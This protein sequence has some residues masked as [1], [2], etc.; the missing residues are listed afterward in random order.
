MISSK[1]I[2]KK[3]MTQKII[4]P[5]GQWPSEIT[6][7]IFANLLK[8]SE[9]AW[10]KNGSLFWR[11]RS[12]SL[13]KIQMS[14][15]EIGQI[16]TIS[17]DLNVGGELLY[18]GGGYSTTK[19]SLITVDKTTH[20]LYRINPNEAK[21]EELTSSLVSA[22]SPTVSPDGKY[23][24]F[25]HSDGETDAI[26][27]TGVSDPLSTQ[28]LISDS[29]F[30][31]YPR[32]HPS[33]SRIAWIS[34]DHPHMPWDESYL[35]LAE[36]DSSAGGGPVLTSK[37][38]IAGGDGT[39]VLQPEFSPDGRYLAYVSEQDGWWQIFLQDLETGQNQ[40]LTDVHAEHGLPAWLQDQRSFQFSPDSCKIFF[41]R[42]QDGIRTLWT[43]DLGSTREKMIQLDE[44]YTW[45]EDISISPDG[46][47]LA[48]IASGADLP[49]RLITV[50]LEGKTRIIRRSS[51]VQLPRDI[52]SIPEPVSW[53]SQEGQK[54]HGL[55]YFPQNSQYGGEGKPPLVMIIHSGP[56]RQKWVDFQTRTQY[57]TSRG[58][59]VLEV[60]Y[61]GSTGYGRQ[62][63]QALKGNWGVADVDDC[64][65]GAIHLA[66]KEL[67]DRKKMVVMGSSSGGMTVYQILV[68]YPG[69]F[70]A[71]ISL[72]GIVNHLSLLKNPPKFERHYSDWLIGHYPE[73][74]EIYHQRSPIFSADNIQDPVA[75][76]QGGK[77]RIVPQDQAEQIVTALEE[78]H[79]PYLYRLYPEE[80]H[81][82]KRVS[83][84]EDFYT[85]L[86]S[87]L[88]T[89]LNK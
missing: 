53:T 30:Y 65:S 5:Y 45:L 15:T 52:F 68:K 82:F 12:S 89:H 3:S 38:L 18:G 62:Y 58:Y 35:Y 31:N 56:T 74:E 54:I 46:D 51:P 4:K 88:D 25:V 80:G 40:Q 66:D 2:L 67:V 48:L 49:I 59:A 6:P 22:A 77:D 44:P 36:L 61:R 41:L 78:N 70:K 71:G 50:D 37:I 28:S 57:F 84:L 8:I 85:Q 79:V 19:N 55:F 34:W 14:T 23:A 75:V 29:D 76:F 24:L 72:Y 32:W 87:F 21:A 1:Y 83:T 81:S 9:P 17:R 64:L 43:L 16:Q 60:N 11:E 27:I 33:G 73:A 42:N 47:Q 86:E 10:G 7:S 20:Q 26:Y 39:S 63:R 13:T 69:I